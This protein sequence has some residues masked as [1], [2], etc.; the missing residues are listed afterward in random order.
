MAETT[1]NTDSSANT[2]TNQEKPRS[3]KGLIYAILIAALAG[4]WGYLIWDKTQNTQEKNQLQTQVVTVDSAKTAIEQQ[5]NAALARLDLLT[6]SN[7]KMDSLVKTKDKDLSSLKYRIR[8]ILDQK[9]LNAQK[10]AEAQVLIGQLQS[11]IDG[12]QA[13]VEK[14]QGEKIV[15]VYQ[16]DSIKN[17]YDTVYAQNQNLNQKVSL[18]SVLIASNIRI[19][20]LHLKHNGR[21]VNTN[22][23]KRADLMRVTFDLDE[24]RIS[25]S[26]S[27]DLYVCITAPDGTPLAVQALGSGRFT[28]ADGTEKLYT[29]K[30]TIDYATGQKQNVSIDWKQNST[31]K[32]GAYKVEIYEAGYEIGNG[33]VS[34]RK[35]GFL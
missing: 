12:Y 3:N 34:M 32:P 13:E 19:L 30:K 5:Y 21:E 15:L 6:S 31:F 18:G 20:P 14:L 35:G 8:S 33:N 28:L 7:S 4:T 9:N 2:G 29:A 25:D 27:K 26:G 16:R 11:S 1:Y 17:Q 23:A 22:K 10:L 24:N